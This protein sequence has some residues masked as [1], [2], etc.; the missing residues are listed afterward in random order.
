MQPCDVEQLLI[1]REYCS[2]MQLTCLIGRIGFTH[3]T[4]ARIEVS[5]LRVRDQPGLIRVHPEVEID[6][7]DRSKCG[8]CRVKRVAIL[9]EGQ[10]IVTQ[11]RGGVAHRQ[12]E[13]A[14]KSGEGDGGAGSIG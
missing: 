1:P 10:G 11:Q 9:R 12:V 7:C 6:R 2:I 4:I 8:V 3:C 13:T 14:R 5:D